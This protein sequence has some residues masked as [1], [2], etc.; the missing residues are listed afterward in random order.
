MPGLRKSGALSPIL[1]CAFMA[2]TATIL[3]LTMY[4]F[5]VVPIHSVGCVK[6][7][8]DIGTVTGPGTG[9]QEQDAGKSLVMEISED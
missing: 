9:I 7:S 6:D 4:H 1:Q 2:C 3:P 8:R 5:N